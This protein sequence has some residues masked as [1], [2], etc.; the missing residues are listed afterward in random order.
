MAWRD[1]TSKAHFPP[2]RAHQVRRPCAR[3]SWACRTKPTT[4]ARA[5]PTPPCWHGPQNA[6][7]RP[8]LR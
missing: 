5:S 6:S 7:S 3:R 4:R 8:Q 2:A 1:A